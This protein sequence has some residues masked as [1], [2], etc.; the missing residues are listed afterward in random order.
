MEFYRFAAPYLAA[1]FAASKGFKY[2]YAS[3]NSTTAAEELR[4]AV[5]EFPGIHYLDTVI[6]KMSKVFNAADSSLPPLAPGCPK[7]HLVEEFNTIYTDAAPGVEELGIAG[8]YPKQDLAPFEEAKLYG[9]NA[10]HCL[11]GVLAAERNFASMDEAAADPELMRKAHAALLDECGRALC[12]KYAGTDE[13]FEPGTFRRWAE[14]LLERMV[15]P[16]LADSVDRVIRDPER[17]LGWNDR[18]I[19]AIRLCLAQNVAPDRLAEGARLLRSR[20][21]WNRVQAGWP[22][23]PESDAVRRCLQ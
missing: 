1:G 15:S 5:G 6:G 19:G 4:R 23:T 7:G 12:G 14:E 16:A 11:L 2:V 10:V 9:H 3:E 17:K 18:L 22:D 20:V 21:D 13:Y 8:L